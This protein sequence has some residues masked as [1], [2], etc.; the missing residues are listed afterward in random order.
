[1]RLACRVAIIA[2]AGSTA[3]GCSSDWTRFDRSLYSSNA[4]ANQPVQAAQTNPY[5]GDID[6]T[7]TSSVGG[8]Q[9]RRGPVPANNVQPGSVAPA[10]QPLSPDNGTQP[11]A[12]APAN[13]SSQVTR[14]QLPT[15]GQTQPTTRI[16][17]VTTSAVRDNNRP[18]EGG[19]KGWSATGGTV[20]TMREGET[21]YNLSRRY[22]VPV[23]E[24]M[25]A[26][27]IADASSVRADQQIIIPTYVYSRTAPV[28]A[29]DN[30]KRTNL[31]NSS[32]GSR[33]VPKP[34]TVPSPARKP[35]SVAAVENKPA[36]TDVRVNTA[37]DGS[38]T[39]ASGDTLSGI[40][41]RNGT[42]VAALMGANSLSGS[43][44]QIG[45]KLVLPG[46]SVQVAQAETE[47]NTLSVD[48]IV[49]GSNQQPDGPK[50]Y[51]KP[52]NAE[53]GT[54]RTVSTDVEA[55]KQTGIGQFRWP[56]RGRVIAAF[57]EK[58]AGVRNDGIDISVPEGTAV[59]ATE[60]GVVVY[61]GDELE[62]LGNLVL[63]RHTDGWVSAYAHN[64]SIEVSRGDE[65]RR[66]E[67][68]AR[69]GRTGN[70]DL[71][72]L[73]FELRRNSNPVDPLKHL[74]GA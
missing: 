16:D 12:Y 10:E 71:P 60:N 37:P 52:R 55:P 29:P 53:N 46:S 27:R 5:P 68:I 54:V 36:S 2:L 25:K 45:Q 74:G 43:Q 21:L 6:T 8:T 61:A 48:P 70:A 24:I 73:H 31:A 9:L 72:K 7:T 69:S 65:V 1:M 15:P 64:K 44:L 66:G 56:V 50:P 49:T 57:G 26:N 32:V 19:E 40:A 14:S 38:Y 58:D 47:S 28:S 22:G 18:R 20:I 51:I 42:T 67:I 17:T 59:K 33:V 13:S 39:V 35:T 34:G 4:T 63:L 30:N 62:G 11:V 23:E 3:V 41:A